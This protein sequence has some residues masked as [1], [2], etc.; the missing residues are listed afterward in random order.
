MHSQQ[1]WHPWRPP[2]GPWRQTS[3]GGFFKEPAEVQALRPEVVSFYLNAFGPVGLGDLSVLQAW[4]K[5]MAPHL[6]VRY[7]FKN[8]S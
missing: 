3:A 1:P 4:R 6:L 7:S 2:R 8:V 5:Q